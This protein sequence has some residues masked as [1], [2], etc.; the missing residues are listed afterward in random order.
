MSN[1]V[2]VTCALTGAVHTPSLS[3]TLPW[4]YEDLIRQG[5]DACNAGAAILHLHGR[6]Q[7]NGSPSSALE[8]F[9]TVMQEIKKEIPDVIFCT[10]TGGAVTMTS[11]E[12]AN[13]VSKLEPE[14]ASF[15]PGSMNFNFSGLASKERDWQFDWEKSYIEATDDMVFRNTFKTI[16]EYGAIFARAGTKAE[17]EIFDIG[18]LYNLL[19]AIKQGRLPEKVHMQFVLGTLGGMPADPESIY[20]LLTE[21]RRIIGDFTFSVSSAGKQQMA[22]M[23]TAMAFGGHVRVGLEDALYIEKGKLAPSN[24]SLVEKVVRIARELGH[25]PATRAEA[26]EILGLKGIDKVKF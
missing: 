18:M 21:A 5:V 16:R 2:I 8:D 20:L 15:T 25:E 11:E 1:K 23:A 17:Y 4:K 7:E 19:T 6:N 14:L 24:A 9:Q 22:M 12:R 26:R 13:V 3:P 10:T